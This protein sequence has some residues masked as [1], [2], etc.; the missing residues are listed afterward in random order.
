LG[1]KKKLQ[2]F[3]RIFQGSK[4]ALKN[5]FVY[6]FLSI[7]SKIVNLQKN[8]TFENQII[9]LK[10]ISENIFSTTKLSHISQTKNF[11][12]LKVKAFERS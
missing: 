9:F 12:K 11:A 7:L 1:T 8:V 6:R 5:G 3:E 2:K 10:H 4:Q